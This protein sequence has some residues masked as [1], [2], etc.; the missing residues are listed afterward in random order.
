MSHI[1]DNAE[2]FMRE[3][4]IDGE[5]PSLIASALINDDW[6]NVIQRIKQSAECFVEELES[7]LDGP[8]NSEQLLDNRERAIDMSESSAGIYTMYGLIK[9]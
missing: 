3:L 4:A 8:D 6:S 9:L 2:R 1:T 5:L 7:E